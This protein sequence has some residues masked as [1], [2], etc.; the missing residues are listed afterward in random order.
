MFSRLCNKLLQIEVRAF[1]IFS[2]YHSTNYTNFQLQVVS[3]KFPGAR[4][5]RC[6]VGVEERETE[7]NLYL[8]VALRV[9]VFSE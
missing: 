7:K 3:Y 5:Q 8:V 6:G 9:G 1:L 2:I 4:A